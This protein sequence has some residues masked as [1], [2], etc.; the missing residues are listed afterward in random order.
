MLFVI[1]L[2]AVLLTIENAVRDARKRQRAY[3]ERAW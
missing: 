1:G 3:L 2:Y